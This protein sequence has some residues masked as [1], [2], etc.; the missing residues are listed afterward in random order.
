MIVCESLG[1]IVNRIPVGV[2]IV[3]RCICITC[4]AAFDDHLHHPTFEE[5]V[6]PIE[7]CSGYGRGCTWLPIGLIKELVQASSGIALLF[8][9][10]RCGQTDREERGWLLIQNIAVLSGESDKLRMMLATV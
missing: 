4:A 3:P 5:T 2:D 1:E 8:H 7:K 10:A 6:L 9:V